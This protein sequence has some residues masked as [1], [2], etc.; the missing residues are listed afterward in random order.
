MS[1]R[2]HGVPGTDVTG[3]IEED[4]LKKAA[5]RLTSDDFTETYGHP[6][7]VFVAAEPLDVNDETRG[8]RFQT[9]VGKAGGA[10][11]YHHR[12]AFIVKR[13]GNPFLNM[14]TIGRAGNNDIVVDVPS[15]S[16]FHAFLEQQKDGAW[17]VTAQP[18]VNGMRVNDAPL[19]SEEKRTLA[20][21]DRIFIGEDLSATFLLPKTLYK[22]LRS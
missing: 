1:G 5:Q 8:G 16:K 18:S 21:G 11:H 19:A 14:I 6:A 17:S 9:A 15:V 10:K 13:P 3:F 2:R 20:D 12:V 22:R 7:L 4:V